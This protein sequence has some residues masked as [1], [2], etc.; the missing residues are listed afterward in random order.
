VADRVEGGVVRIS[1]RRRGTALEV[2]VENPRDPE[3]PPRRGHGLGLRNVRQRLEALDPR[4][5]RMDVL[6]EPERFRVTLTLPAVEAGGAHAA[7]GG[8]AGGAPRD[9]AAAAGDPEATG[10]RG[11]AARAGEP[12]RA[13]A[14]AARAEGRHAV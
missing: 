13:P 14:P 1:A 12:E 5:S 4:H 6:G 11:T 9:A 3:A 2:A 8:D 7:A 10:R